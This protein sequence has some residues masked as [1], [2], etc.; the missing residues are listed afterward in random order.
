MITKIS[1]GIVTVG[2]Y[3][4]VPG[5]YPIEEFTADDLLIERRIFWTY[6]QAHPITGDVF[7]NLD[8]QIAREIDQKCHQKEA[9]GG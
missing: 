3:G 2:P 8:D 1:N 5:N 7:R 9:A 4:F 6:C